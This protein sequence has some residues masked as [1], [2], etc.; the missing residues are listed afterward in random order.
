MKTNPKNLAFTLLELMTVLAVIVVLTAMVVGVAG[1]VSRRSSA[2]RATTEIAMLSLAAEIA[3]GAACPDSPASSPQT[4]VI[5]QQSE[6]DDRF[7]DEFMDS[8]S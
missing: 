7:C 4:S 5:A 2:A 3:A 8:K 6:A 1:L